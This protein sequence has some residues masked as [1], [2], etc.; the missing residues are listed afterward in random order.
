VDGTTA[1]LEAFTDKNIAVVGGFVHL[2]STAT[3]GIRITEDAGKVSFTPQG[4]KSLALNAIAG[5]NAE[6]VT[7][8]AGV[9]VGGNLGVTGTATF[10]EAVT[11]NSDLNVYGTLNTASVYATQAVYAQDNV[12]VSG[13]V[14]MRRTG[15]DT[16]ISLLFAAQ[17][18]LDSLQVT[19]NGLP[20]AG[21]LTALTSAVDALT[22]RVV[23]LESHFA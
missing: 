22:A 5:L 23:A 10:T 14:Y 13:D 15:V 3:T 21:A 7:T 4:S 19:V 17:S 6:S 11:S 2:G 1:L 16:N 12:I 20:S 8:S 18:A 9:A